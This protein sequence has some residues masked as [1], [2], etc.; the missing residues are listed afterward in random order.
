[1]SGKRANIFGQGRPERPYDERDE[2]AADPPRQATAA[3]LATRKFVVRP[4]SRSL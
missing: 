3:Q 2:D 1:M 4:H